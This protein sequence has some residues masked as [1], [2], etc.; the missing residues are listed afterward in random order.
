VPVAGVASKIDKINIKYNKK[1]PVLAVWPEGSLKKWGY[2]THQMPSPFLSLNSYALITLYTFGKT[3]LA[4]NRDMCSQLVF[5][6]HIT[7]KEF[8]SRIN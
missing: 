3:V 4:L 7:R 5:C 8:L 6:L 1:Q 2:I